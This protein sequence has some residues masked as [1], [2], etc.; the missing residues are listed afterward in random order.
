MGKLSP[1]RRVGIRLVEGERL[2]GVDRRLD[3]ARELFEHQVLVLHLVDETCG[4]EQA[5]FV[6]ESFEAWGGRGVRGEFD[7]LVSRQKIGVL[8][9][10]ATSWID[11]LIDQAVMFHMEYLVDGGQ[12]DVLVATAITADEV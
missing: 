3:L 6:S 2:E 9:Q 4:L 11:V 12:R 10:H 8:S 1:N 5:F 7:V